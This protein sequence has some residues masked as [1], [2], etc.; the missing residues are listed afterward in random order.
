M[1]QPPRTST[2][3]ALHVPGA[4]LAMANAWDIGSAK[5]LAA[6]G[7]KALATTSSACVESSPPLTPITGL[8][9]PMAVIRWTSPDTWMLKAS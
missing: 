2:F 5:L 1:T 8:G 7:F 3:R 4:P 9:P 6:V